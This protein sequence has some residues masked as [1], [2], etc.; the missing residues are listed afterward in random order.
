METSPAQ[1]V[2]APATT[3]NGS[4]PF[5]FG[6][7]T[8]PSSAPPAFTFGSTQSPHASSA[9]SSQPTQFNFPSPSRPGTP[10]KSFGN[11]MATTQFGSSA[12]APSSPFGAAQ[13]LPAPVFTFG[14]SGSQPPP[15]GPS[16]PPTFS[17]T[18]SPVASPTLSPTTL[19]SSG[20]NAPFVFGAGAEVGS[21]TPVTPTTPN[22]RPLRGLPQRKKR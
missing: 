6:A 22:R 19:G 3:T 9:A 4:N 7:Q 18:F 21:Q 15:S 1:S 17:F 5:T 14:S 12:G 10:S 2:T 11:P 8:A 16:A 20:P 13:Q